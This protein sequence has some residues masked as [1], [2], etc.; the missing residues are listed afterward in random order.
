MRLIV[1]HGKFWPVHQ[2][3]QMALHP[4]RTLVKLMNV[5]QNH[6]GTQQAGQSTLFA[7]PQSWQRKVIR[8]TKRPI[9]QQI[10]FPLPKNS[11]K[12]PPCFHI[13]PLGTAFG[14]SDGNIGRRPGFSCWPPLSCFWECSSLAST[15]TLFLPPGIARLAPLTPFW[16]GLAFIFSREA[17]FG[18][19]IPTC[20][21]GVKSAFAFSWPLWPLPLFLDLGKWVSGQSAKKNFNSASNG[22]IAQSVAG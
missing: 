15:R 21:P 16:L 5:P 14:E 2:S 6:V 9:R 22:K 12:L 4:L 7:A 3:L 10:L 8:P 19:P 1:E 17:L 11:C 13:V 18:F 20:P